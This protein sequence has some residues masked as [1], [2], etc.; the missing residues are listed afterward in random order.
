MAAYFCCAGW[1]VVYGMRVLAC[2][3]FLKMEIFTWVQC[4][5]LQYLHNKVL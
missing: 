2:V 3:G 5:I 4:L 1:L